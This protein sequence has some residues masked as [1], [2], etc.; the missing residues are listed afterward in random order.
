MSW[1]KS[2]FCL[3]SLLL[4]T[5]SSYTGAYYYV[6]LEDLGVKFIEPFLIYWCSGFFDSLICHVEWF[7]MYLDIVFC[8][9]HGKQSATSWVKIMEHI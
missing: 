5:N 4:N 2:D 7:L 6:F 8:I 9:E 3:G 1:K